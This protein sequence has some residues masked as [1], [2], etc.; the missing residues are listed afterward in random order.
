MSRSAQSLIPLALIVTVLPWQVAQAQLA[1]AAPTP[2]AGDILRDESPTRPAMPALPN[3]APLDASGHVDEAPAASFVLRRFEVHGV[4]AFRPQQISA[5]AEPYI[6]KTLS[7]DDL[8]QL[9][10][11]LRKRYEDEGLGLAS[12]GFPTQDVSQGVLKVDVIEPKLGRVQVPL[13][14]DAPVSEERVKGLMNSFCLHAGGLLNTQSLERVMFALND[15]PGVQAKASLSPSG[16]EA[17]YNLSIQVTP[18]R[19]WD[20]SVAVDN[21][22]ASYAGRWRATGLY[23]LNNPLRIG[24]NLDLQA[25][26]S[27]SG[28]VSVGRIA[29]ELPVGYSPAR[30]SLAYAQ[31][32]YALGRQ[33]ADLNPNG[34]AYVGEANLSVPLVRSRSRTVMARVGY[35]EKFLRDHLTV[36]VTGEVTY[37]KHIRA[38]VAGLNMESRDTWLGGGFNGASAQFHWGRLRLDSV[39]D[40]DDDAARGSFGHAGTFGKVELQYSRLQSVSRTVSLYANASQ[41]LAS[42]N[43]DPAEKM[44]LGGPRGVRAYPSAEGASDEATLFTSELRL[45]LNRNWTAFALYDWAKGRRERDTS[46][47]NFDTNDLMLHGAGLGLVAS[48]PDWVTLKATVAWR[49]KRPVETEPGNDK[50]RVFVQAQHSF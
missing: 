42:R 14:K 21:H 2:R 9:I 25:I 44:S 35:E 17:V 8:A 5:L 22:G 3:V 32:D 26:R 36:P 50:V 15:S 1:A 49:G 41:Q 31:V 4:T 19:G 43:L 24:D 45:W 13:G 7:E 16:D 23:R 27:S 37:A 38:S 40:Q 6:G 47:A 18:R 46:P 34:T 30:L 28:G 12:I 29:Y 33:F 20:A 11:A 39:D 10:G 48:Y